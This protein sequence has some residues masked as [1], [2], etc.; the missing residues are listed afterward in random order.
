[1]SCRA[2]A[3]LKSVR[4]AASRAADPA[5]H[6][7][8]AFAAL[9]TFT[10]ATPADAQRYGYLTPLDQVDAADPLTAAIELGRRLHAAGHTPPVA[11]PAFRC[12]G[13]RTLEVLRAAQSALLETGKL[14]AHQFD[15]NMRMALVL[16]GGDTA[17]PVCTEA[18]LFAMERLHLIALL[19][20]PLT[21][22]RIEH[23]RRTGN[24]LAN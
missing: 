14:T 17:E 7:V 22:A 24:S 1:V 2:A 16:C 21:Q 15:I 3:V 18:E 6:I 19:Q 13:S 8:T 11:N 9:T 23:L 12:T 20:T 4:Y 5:Q 10:R